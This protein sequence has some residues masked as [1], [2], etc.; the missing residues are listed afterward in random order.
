MPREYIG[1]VTGLFPTPFGEMEFV[2]TQ[3]DHVHLTGRQ[4]SVNR[5]TYRANLHLYRQE[6][7]TWIP[8]DYNSTYMSRADVIGDS[9][10]DAAR[11]KFTEGARAAWED[12]IRGQ[13]IPLVEAE[14]AYLNNQ[15]MD[16]E[17]ELAKRIE[18]VYVMETKRSGLLA[19]EREMLDAQ[20]QFSRRGGYPG[21][22][23]WSPLG[24]RPHPRPES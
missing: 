21:P 2:I 11:R 20:A 18:A 4:I 13:D 6:D 17:E 8:K 19:Q 3:G 9:G 7:E 22:H 16:A 15:L 1:G 23:D 12:F 5:V 24:R 10:T 14:L